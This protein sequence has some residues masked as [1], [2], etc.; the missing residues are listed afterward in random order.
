MESKKDIEAEIVS[1]KDLIEIKNLAIPPYQRPYRWSTKNVRQLLEDILMSKNAGKKNY[2]IGSVILH[3]NVE[4]GTLDL[5]DGQ[6]RITT[7]FLLQY[8]C[9][10]EVNDKLKYKI[11][12]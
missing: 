8:A 6:Q 10:E 12:F 4:N 3:D 9:V 11:I 1:V 2:R 5:V 7:L